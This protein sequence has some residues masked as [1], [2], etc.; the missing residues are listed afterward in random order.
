[1]IKRYAQSWFFVKRS[2]TSFPT[3]FCVWFFSRKI[4]LLYSINWANV[5]VW[6]ILLLEILGNTCIVIFTS[7]W[8]HKF[9]NQPE[10]SYQAIFLHDQKSRD[11]NLNILRTKRVFNTK[12]KIL[13][14]IFDDLPLKQIKPTFGRW[15]S[16]FKCYN[17]WCIARF[18]II[19]T[20]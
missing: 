11:K 13:S 20:I 3:I 10:L 15:E 16:E 7:L 17:M 14:I 12:Y 5:I 8:R 6:L 1:M 9:W 18:G 4:F 19:C 2:G